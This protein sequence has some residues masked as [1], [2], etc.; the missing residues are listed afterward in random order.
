MIDQAIRNN[1]KD[2]IRKGDY[3]I[4][5]QIYQKL[6]KKRITPRYLH[7]FIHGTH[8]PTGQRP[9]THD[10]LRMFEAVATAVRQRQTAAQNANTAAQKLIETILIDTK[11]QPI[12]A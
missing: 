4:A 1:L 5:A 2:Q 11:P 9:G 6:V 3:E 7:K 12:P 8:N 10:P